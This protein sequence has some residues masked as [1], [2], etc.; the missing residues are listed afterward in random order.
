VIC[1]NL[2]HIGNDGE[3]YVCGKGGSFPKIT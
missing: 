1:S 3:G 2:V